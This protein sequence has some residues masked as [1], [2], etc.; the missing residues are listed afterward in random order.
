MQMS[1]LSADIAFMPS[2]QSDT[3]M[4]PITYLAAMG[5]MYRRKARDSNPKPLR[6]RTP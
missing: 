4:V 1:T 3:E 2:R 6:A 5:T